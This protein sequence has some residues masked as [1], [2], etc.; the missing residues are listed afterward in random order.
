MSNIQINWK[1]FTGQIASTV[2]ARLILSLYLSAA[3]HFFSPTLFL[4]LVS[5][6]HIPL[7]IFESMPSLLF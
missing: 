1:L 7:Y 6:A 2:F 4:L 3:Y 5:P